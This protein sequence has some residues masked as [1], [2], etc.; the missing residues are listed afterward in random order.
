MVIH[1][2]LL[3]GTLLAMLL[4]IGGLLLAAGDTEINFTEKEDL[5]ALMDHILSIDSIGLV[6]LG[7][8]VIIAT[9]LARIF[10]TITI[11]TMGRDRLLIGVGLAVFIIILIGF[12]Q[13]IV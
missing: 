12:L 13:G 5:S 1:R 2:I 6:V 7:I 11:F 4:L 10:A 8:L 3:G 9:P